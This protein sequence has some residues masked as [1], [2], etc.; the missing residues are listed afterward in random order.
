[1]EVV[2]GKQDLQMAKWSVKS[3]GGDLALF[4]QTV[5][6]TLQ[7]TSTPEFFNFKWGA[8]LCHIF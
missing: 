3:L 6:T 5:T 4:T 1:M 2:E 8:F 7:I